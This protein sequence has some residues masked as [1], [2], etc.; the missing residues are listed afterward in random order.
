MRSLAGG[1][2]WSPGPRFGSA[3]FI[4][5]KNPQAQKSKNPA[6]IVGAVLAIAL[7]AA[8]LALL[9]R[10]TPTSVLRTVVPEITLTLSRI[11]ERPVVV[12]LPEM[13]DLPTLAVPSFP[14]LSE[15]EAPA[16]G[17]GALPNILR[18][19]VPAGGLNISLFNCSLENQ[20]NLSAQQRAQCQWSA[21]ALAEGREP[22]LL[23][24]RS[25]VE[26][27]ARWANALAH[28][29]S[30]LILPCMGGLDLLCVIRNVAGLADGSTLDP[31]SSLRDP[32]QWGT[33]VD[34]QQFMPRDPGSPAAVPVGTTVP[35]H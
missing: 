26:D 23:G 33:Y 20:A 27:N 5:R 21:G 12:P 32:E 30:P 31:E 15:L 28:R 17:A 8:F 2:S 4:G 24:E 22:D 35:G 13:E 7:Q 18:G 3:A 34:P 9:I 25:H 19:P 16:M 14:H 1:D 29:K 10:S 11:Q 6:R